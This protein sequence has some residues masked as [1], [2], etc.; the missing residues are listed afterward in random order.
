MTRNHAGPSARTEYEFRRLVLPRTTS[1]TAAVRMLTE[2]AEYGHWELA[3][4]RLQPDGSRD[5][6]LR[7][8]ILRWRPDRPVG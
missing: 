3:R 8:T 7:R 1:R 6:L 4:L 2:Q 5:V